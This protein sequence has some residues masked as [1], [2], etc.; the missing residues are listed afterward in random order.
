MGKLRPCLD[1]T[2]ISVSLETIYLE[3]NSVQL[4]FIGY[5]YPML[6]P[7]VLWDEYGVRM[8]GVDDIAYMKLSAIANRGSRKDFIDLH[9]IISNLQPLPY[10]LRLFSQKYQQVDIGHIVRSLFFRGCGPRS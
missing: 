8:A 7:P 5:G 10:Y 6:E 3:I 4:S 1:F 9:Y 2:V